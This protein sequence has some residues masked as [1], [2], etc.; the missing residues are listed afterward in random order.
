MRSNLLR[1]VF[2]L[3]LFIPFAANAQT[4]F[5]SEYVEG[6]SNNKALEIYNPGAAPV[7]LAGWS[8]KMYFNGSASP[9]LTIGL[10]GTV[11]PGATHVVAH[12]AAASEILAVAQQTN[13]AGWFNG[14]DAVA[15]VQ[16]AAVIDVIGQIGFDPGS[17]WGSGTA[18]TA[19]NTIRRKAS[20]CAGDTNGADA[21]IPSLEWDGFATNTFTG[22]GAHLTSDCGGTP[23]PPPPPVTVLEIHEIQ[24]SGLSSTYAG[25]KVKTL[26]NVVTAVA[27]DGFFIQVPDSGADASALTSNGIFVFTGSAPTV[28]AGDLVDVEGNVAEFFDFTELSSVTVTR[29]SSGNPLPQP[30]VLGATVPSPLQPASPTELERFEGML[31]RLTNGRATAGSD[32]FGDVS[33]VA[34]P[35]RPFREPGMVYPGQAGL[36]VWDGNPEIFE[37]DPDRLGLA[38]GPLVGGAEIH[39]AEG[40]L[41]FSFGDYQIWPSQL[42]FT[43]PAFPRPVRARASGEMTVASQNML[44][45]FDTVAP[46]TMTPAALATKLAKLSLLVRETLGAPDVLAASEVENVGVLDMLATQIRLDDPTIVYTPLLEEGNDIGGID[47]GFL[48]RDTFQVASV[49][50]LGATDT[51]EYNGLSAIIFDRPPLLLRGSYV[52]NGAPFDVAVIAVHLRS[53]ND[54]ETS[55]RVRVKRQAGALRLAELIDGLLDA[56]PGLRL[57]V[58]GDF[59]AFEFSDGYVDVL[60]QLTG[61]AGLGAMIPSAAVET[62]QGM[63]NLVLGVSASDRYSYTHE[64]SAQVLD[65]ALA[66]SAALEYV[67]ELAFARVNADAPAAPAGDAATA[68]GVSD[69]DGLTVFLMTDYDGDY[70]ADDVDACATGDARPTVVVGDCDSG[71]ANPIGG[72]GCTLADSIAAMRAGARNHGQFVSALAH[73]L[74]EK[75]RAG[76]MTEQDRASIQSCAAQSN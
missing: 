30:V 54:I 46:E 26:A 51:F 64:G 5:F 4:L 49:V 45:F 66:S 25:Q 32:R 36:P 10:S 21:F 16:G 52:A 19:D 40:P 12:S 50:Q 65:H 20:I 2:A 24:G 47:V 23:P 69:H 70:V 75:V 74:S 1:V 55:E 28:L 27:S 29:V 11:L 3:L 39:V 37:M 17:E 31:V 72:D 76:E 60:A 8:V 57:V 48:V 43:N 33:I 7:S 68:A 53:L 62:Y 15:L 9:G 18:S 42:E 67:R 71:V 6:S 63:A 14:D 44:Q 59:N 13:G 61:V 22:L 41:G 34:T 58:A 38:V 56:E 35:E 73:Y